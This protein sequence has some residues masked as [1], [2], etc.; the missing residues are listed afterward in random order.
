[1]LDP[2]GRVV[3]LADVYTEY[4][5]LIFG[6][7]ATRTGYVYRN[8]WNKRV[9]ATLG[10]LPVGSITGLD[11][12]MAWA[13]WEGSASTK[14]DALA[15]TSKTLSIAVEAGLIRSNPA[16]GLRL[17]RKPSKSPA[18]RGGR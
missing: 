6:D 18:A 8:A 10:H 12:R 4:A 16:R 1:M 3:T 5:L 15:V 7:V 2:V 17:K 14:T 13:S 11:I 9:A